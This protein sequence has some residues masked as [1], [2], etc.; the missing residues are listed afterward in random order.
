MKCELWNWKRF[1]FQSFDILTDSIHLS[2][3]IF[4]RMATFGIKTI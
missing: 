1:E 2:Q 4:V 3:I